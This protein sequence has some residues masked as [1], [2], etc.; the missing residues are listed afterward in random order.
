MLGI[1][2]TI[3]IILIVMASVTVGCKNPVSPVQGGLLDPEKTTPL[4]SVGIGAAGNISPVIQ[5]TMQVTIYHGTND[6]MYLS[7][8][9]HVVPKNDHPAQTAIEL[10]VAGT[11]NTALASVIPPGTKLKK[12]WIKDHIAYVSFNDQ[13]IKKS[14]GGSTSE[15]LLVSAI[16][17][18][19]TLFP[20]IQKVQILVDGE[21]IDTISGHMDTREPLSR[22]EKMIK[23]P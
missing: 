13:L 1:R 7:P 5:E 16:V 17:N 21:K 2:K 3:L 8:E 20:N 9:I 23:N 19:L 14:T 6:A 12:L 4:K 10:L 15:I 11:K 22:L 18:T